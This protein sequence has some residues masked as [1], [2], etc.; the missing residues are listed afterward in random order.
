MAQ[1]PRDRLVR[2]EP[3]VAK[4]VL[5]PDSRAQ[6]TPAQMVERKLVSLLKRTTLPA[7]CLQ[8]GPRRGPF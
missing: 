5:V 7:S 2:I 6:L 4:E 1:E 3:I 8:T